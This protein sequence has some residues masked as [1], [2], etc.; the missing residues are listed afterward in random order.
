MIHVLNGTI[1]GSTAVIAGV[2]GDEAEIL[3]LEDASK[4]A[5]LNAGDAAADR[6]PR[7]YLDAVI[8]DCARCAKGEGSAQRLAWACRQSAKLGGY[9]SL[10]GR[11]MGGQAAGHAGGE[12]RLVPR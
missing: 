5:A 10:C 1:D 3:V 6:F 4:T 12:H 2:F 11:L 8:C 7:L 9:W